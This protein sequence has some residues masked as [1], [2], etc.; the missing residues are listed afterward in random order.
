MPFIDSIMNN[1]RTGENTSHN[2]IFEVHQEQADHLLSIKA[3]PGSE[4]LVISTPPRKVVSKK[5]RMRL[6]SANSANSR[7]TK[8]DSI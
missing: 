2:N 7:L 1:E 6:N 4:K 5:Y 8:S 3:D